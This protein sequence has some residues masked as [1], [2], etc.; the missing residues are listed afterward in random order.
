MVTENQRSPC[1]ENSRCSIEKPIFLVSTE[2]SGSTLLRLMLDHHPNIIF[3]HESDYIVDLVS[4]DG[5]LPS[6][7]EFHDIL[8][9]TCGFDY[10]IDRSLNYQDLVTDFL[11]Q[12][13]ARSGKTGYIGATLHKNFNRLTYLWP[14]ARFIHLI[15]DPRDVTRSVVQKGWAG[16]LYHAAE[17]WID[18][19]RCWDALVSRLSTDRFIE[20]RYENL[21]ARPEDELSR[22]CKWIGVSFDPEMLE[23]QTTAIQYPKPNPALAYQ[24]KKKLSLIFLEYCHAIS[25]NDCFLPI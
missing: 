11:R 8:N 12:K 4:D 9:K 13:L 5:T 1:Q 22:I 18:A 24:W 21:V 17:W 6:L 19:E 20:V 14:D 16:N 7:A 10:H 15:R 23:Y 25:L 3:E 2:R